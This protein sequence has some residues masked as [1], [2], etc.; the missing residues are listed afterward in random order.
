MPIKT[1]TMIENRGLNER[2]GPGE[3]TMEYG[4]GRYVNAYVID[5]EMS[6]PGVSYG[7]QGM[8]ATERVPADATKEQIQAAMRRVRNRARY[9]YRSQR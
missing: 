2:A 6:I 4:Y 9:R 7:N 8:W 5:T 1:Y 3:P